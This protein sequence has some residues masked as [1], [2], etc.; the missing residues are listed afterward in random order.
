M[1]LINKSD[2]IN[3]TAETGA[4]ETQSRVRQMPAIINIPDHATNG[5]V[6]NALFPNAKNI[7]VDGGYPLNYI[8]EGEWHRN[9]KEW[10][11]APYKA[12]DTDG[13][14]RGCD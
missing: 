9:L 7:R 5:D 11:D 13:N 8:I 6:I 14:S 12:G 4:L 3:I 2:V 10:W 1:E